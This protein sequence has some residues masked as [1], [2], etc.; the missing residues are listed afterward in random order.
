[1]SASAC[2]NR[3]RTQVSDEGA[4]IFA[5]RCGQRL[6]LKLTASYGRGAGVGRGLVDGSGL[7]VDAGVLVAVAVGVGGGVGVPPI[8]PWTVTAIAPPVLKKPI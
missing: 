7:A 4:L 8:G 6:P 3:R 5:L 2:P 1:M